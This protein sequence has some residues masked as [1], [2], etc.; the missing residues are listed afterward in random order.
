MTSVIVVINAGVIGLSLA[1]AFGIAI[2]LVNSSRHGPR[3]ARV[4][5]TRPLRP[6]QSRGT[7]QGDLP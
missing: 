1:V 3:A 4:P 2:G 7:N 5:S 6:R